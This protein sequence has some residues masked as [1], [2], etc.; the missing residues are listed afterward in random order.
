MPDSFPQHIKRYELEASETAA[1][2]GIDN[3]IPN[4]LLSNAISLANWLQLLRIRLHEHF[5]KERPILITSG[6][7]SPP[8][9]S[10]VGGSKTSAHRFALAADIKVPGVRSKELAEFIRDHMADIEFDQVINEFNQWVHIGLKP[11]GTKPR[12]QALTA[13]K[14]NGRT[15]YQLLG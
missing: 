12:N 2:L 10:A 4:A 7:R 15:E 3:T 5:G 8:L 13:V 14:I 1:R 9:N 6:Y 11:E